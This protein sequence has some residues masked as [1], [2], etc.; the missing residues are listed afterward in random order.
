MRIALLN[1]TFLMRRP[2]AELAQ[3]LAAHGHEVTVIWP[4]DRRAVHGTQ[5]HFDRLLQGSDKITVLPIWSREIGAIL[6]NIPLDWRLFGKLWKVGRTHDVVQVWAPFYPTPLLPFVMKRLG[7]FRARLIGTYDTI[8]SYSFSMGRITD[9]LFRMFFFFCTRPFLNAAETTT[10]YSELLRSPALRAGF[11]GDRLRVVPTGVFPK[12]LPADRNLRTELKL[13]STAPIILFIGL[14]NNRKGIYKLLTMAEQ[15]RAD[16]VDFH[17]L[18]VGTG[19]ERDRFH[20]AIRERGLE[21]VI[22]APGRRHDIHNAYAVASVL[23][24]PA[25]G[26]GLPGVIFEALSYGVPVVASDIPCI[27]DLVQT[28]VNGWLCSA[29]DVG[30]FSAALREI[31]TDVALQK[32]LAKAA[33]EGSQ[34]WDW[35]LQYPKFVAVYEGK[36]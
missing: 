32:R 9:L 18:V 23:V 13:P 11:R 29:Q 8:P 25:E 17:F 19:P 3:Q 35:A 1:P 7:L 4:T 33:K 20:A 34:Q 24:L 27:P 5:L 15:L 6:W 30:A 36:K 28:G 10:L 21:K 14:L 2:I 22:T 16:K 31:I 12:V 26:E